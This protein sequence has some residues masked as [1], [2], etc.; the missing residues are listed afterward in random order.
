VVAPTDTICGQTGTITK[1]LSTASSNGTDVSS[2]NTIQLS[3]RRRADDS[4]TTTITN[5][6]TGGDLSDTVK[7]IQGKILPPV[8]V[9]AGAFFL[10]A[11]ILR[12]TL[13]LREDRQDRDRQ[14]NSGGNI[15][16]YRLFVGLLALSTAL[17]FGAA[18]ASSEAVASMTFILSEGAVG[19]KF[20]IDMGSHLIGLQWATFGIQTLF[21]T[22]MTALVLKVHGNCAS[23][24]DRGMLM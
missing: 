12:L 23:S 22:W 3:L 1:M 5:S 7:A 15:I 18:I 10:V 8:I 19:E 14:T 2:S 9:F 21:A 11:I 13:K 20:A 16:I 4:N 24:G 17:V 6:T